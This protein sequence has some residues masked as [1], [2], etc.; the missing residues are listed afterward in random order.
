MVALAVKLSQYGVGDYWD[1]VEAYI[2]N[3][4]I[5]HQ[6][7]DRD[8][9]EQE[10]VGRGPKWEP[11]P[12]QVISDRLV[13][14]AIGSFARTPCPTRV[15]TAWT[16]C[17]PANGSQ[18]LYYAWEG[19]L[20]HRDGNVQVN[21]LLN[22]VSPWLD[23]SSYLP[24]EGKVVLTNK[25]ANKVLVRVPRWVADA[26][27]KLNVNGD[28]IPGQWFGRYVLVDRL[29]SGDTVTMEFPVVQETRSY[30]IEGSID[31][32][33]WESKEYTCTFKGNTLIDIDSRDETLERD[34]GYMAD[35]TAHGSI[36]IYLRDHLKADKAPMK[37]VSR[38]VSE[39][40]PTW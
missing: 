17:C 24:Y 29:K 40:A 28:E 3:Q 8:L 18:A 6:L 11:D 33:R 4:M 22:R 16:V 20:E 14:R 5:E 25:S 19:I 10:V 36:P 12:P 9:I 32:S 7:T 31:L 2:R 38:F 39:K 1:D 13:D 37:K 35:P 23:V 27:L 34:H 15:Y 21:M 26:D 30:R